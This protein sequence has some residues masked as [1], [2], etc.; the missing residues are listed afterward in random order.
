MAKITGGIS[1]SHVPLLGHIVDTGESQSEQ[2]RPV[3]SGYDFTR[4][5]M[6][7]E[8][9]DVVVLVYNDHAS[10]FDMKVIPTFAIGCGDSF[11]PADEGYG[12]RPVPLVEG[13]PNL[14]WHI[15]QSVILQGF[16]ITII[17]E[18][19]VDHGLTVPLS[20]AFGQPEQWPC[21]VIPLA[22]NT[23]I[24]PAPT[25]ERCLALGKA[26]RKAVKSFDDDINVQVWGTG[27]MSH[28][29]L[30]KRAGLINREWDTAFM[31]K[32]KEDYDELA[33]I[34]Q[35]EYIRESG[36]EGAET[37]MWLIMRGAL[38]KTVQELHRHYHIPVS[39]TALGHLVYS[40][41]AN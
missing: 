13:A 11:A 33:K 40:C 20:L 19:E 22:V 25:G 23:V 38:G 28:Q 8:K 39:N 30:G 2:W 21:K 7:E 36:T 14:A 31:D 32:L 26:I 5:W 6:K 4:Q 10:A 18:M 35:V 24:Y 29:L 16:D 34:P 9:P 15:A 3:F 17:N 1:T 12:A 41:E 37:V 27:G